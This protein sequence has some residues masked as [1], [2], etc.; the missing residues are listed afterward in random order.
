MPALPARKAQRARCGLRRQYRL[1][2]V[3][4]KWARRHAWGEAGVERGWGVVVAGRDVRESFAVAH[5]SLAFC[6]RSSILACKPGNGDIETVLSL[7]KAELSK[8]ASRCKAS[9]PTFL[10][11]AGISRT[12]CLENV[13]SVVSAILLALG[14]FSLGFRLV[15]WLSLGLRLINCFS[16]YYS[17]PVVAELW[18][19]Q[20]YSSAWL[21]NK[22]CVCRGK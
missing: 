13:V 3:A 4:L 18:T 19:K 6:R 10:R 21:I 8:C 15:F 14:W 9:E 16:P 17:E 11:C 12:T 7:C 1:F 5:L 20:A 22:F 2:A